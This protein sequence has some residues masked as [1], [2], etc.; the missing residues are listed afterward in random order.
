MDKEQ[1]LSLV[2]FQRRKAHALFCEAQE[3]EGKL[4]KIKWLEHE[5]RNIKNNIK[6]AYDNMEYDA[7]LKLITEA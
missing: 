1:A 7:I 3:L 4:K 6:I 2:N 5:A